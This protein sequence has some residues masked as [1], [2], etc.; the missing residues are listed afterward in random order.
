METLSKSFFSTQASGI[1]SRR[2][3]GIVSYIHP[4]TFAF[5]A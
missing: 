3:G 1:R 2:I 5:T 4:C